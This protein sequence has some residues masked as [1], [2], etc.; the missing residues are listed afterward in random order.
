MKEAIKSKVSTKN[1]FYKKYIQ[2]GGFEN[3]FIY[4]ENFII[5]LNKLISSCKAFFYENLAKK[6]NSPLLQAEAYCSILKT[7]YNN[8]KIPIIPPLLVDS[9]FVTDIKTKANIFK[10]YFAE[11]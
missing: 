4:L 5:E 7:F 6:L 9:K 10:E 1:V 3:E 2:N 11:Q 8:K